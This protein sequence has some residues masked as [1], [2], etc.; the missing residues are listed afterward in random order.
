MIISKYII[1][2]IINEENN[3]DYT[4]ILFICIIKKRCY[5]N[6]KKRNVIIVGSKADRD[7]LFIFKIIN[8]IL[9]I[10][11]K[12]IFVN[13]SAKYKIFIIYRI[14]SLFMP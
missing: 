11:Y 12:N 3:N 6:R 13:F 1:G 4:T 10:I 14:K 2:V 8:H 7:Y 9:T 5:C